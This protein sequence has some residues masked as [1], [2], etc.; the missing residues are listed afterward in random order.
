LGRDDFLVAA[1]NE[2]AVRWLDLWPRWPGHALVLTG[3]EGSGKSHLASVFASRAR[4]LLMAPETLGGAA[5]RDRV[6]DARAVAVDDAERAPEVAL[7][8][9]YNLIVERQGHLLLAAREPPIRWQIALPD[10]RSRLL[11]APL[12]ELAPPDDALLGAVLAKLFADRQLV[13]GG[14]VV[15]YLVARIE[16]SFAAAAAAV[17]LLDKAALAAQH[18]ITIPFTRAVMEF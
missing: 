1:A 4:A 12:V 16:R 3:P 13:V 6:G 17:D 7:F 11:G 5:L 9:L 8:H 10:L 2:V 18:A 15:A 14:E